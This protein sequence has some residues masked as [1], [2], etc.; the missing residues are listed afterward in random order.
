MAITITLYKLAKAVNST[1]RPEDSG[2]AMEGVLK[3]PSSMLNPSIKFNIGT[4]S[5]NNYNYAY[6]PVFDRYY[7]IADWNWD[8][9]FWIASMKV[10]VMA[11][12]KNSIGASTQY[13]LR[14][15]H[16]SDGT[17]T[18]SLYPCKNRLSVNNIPYSLWT[19][20]GTFMIGMISKD[21]YKGSVKYYRLSY[22][23]FILLNDY[24]MRNVDW[25]D[26][27]WSLI[28]DLSANLMKTLFNP[29]QY[30]TCCWWFPFD[31]DGYGV[32]TSM[33]YGWWSLPLGAGDIGTNYTREFSATISIPS[34]PQISRGIYMQSAPYTELVLIDPVFGTIS[35]QPVRHI[36]GK[37]VY[38]DVVID[39]T[40]GIGT[41]QIRGDTSETYITV[42]AQIGVPMQVSQMGVNYW[43]TYKSQLSMKTN[44]LS[45]LLG[46]NVADA[47]TSIPSGITNML[48][49]LLPTFNS[50]GGNGSFAKF[51]SDLLGLR[52]HLQVTQYYAVDDDNIHNGRPLCQDVQISD[53]PGYII[54]E[55]PLLNIN[56]TETE[57]NEISAIM[58]GG[59]YFE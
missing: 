2:V 19:A 44:A 15:S 33:S 40:N 14:S 7:W 50:V 43:E 24:L 55:R 28:T 38:I 32:I 48:D 4:E 9:G 53:I 49:T 23:E 54:T 58:E 34:H 45:S 17:I 27:D 6:I 41:M 20:G 11:S 29:Y 25:L 39:L 46:G 57:K 47:I 42:D 37:K 56:A 8:S 21:A 3:E 10:D 13:V 35:L 31:I 52:P 26:I 5:P 51:E 22:A 30:I 36:N 59:F 1:K 16:S 12:W 18:D